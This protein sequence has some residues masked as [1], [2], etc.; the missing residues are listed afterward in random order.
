MSCWRRH[1]AIATRA[2]ADRISDMS[3]KIINDVIADQDRREAVLVRFQSK[4]EHAEADACWPWV[5]KAKHKFGYGV[6]NAGG[7]KTVN[8]HCLAWALKNGPI[9][10]GAF[11]LHSCDNPSCC[12]PAHLYLGDNARNMQDMKDRGR[13]RLGQTHSPEARANIKRGRSLNPP[14]QTEAG[15]KSRSEA[16]KRRWESQ[17]WREHFANLTSGE[18]NPRFGK[19]P[20]PHQIEAAKRANRDRAGYKHSEETK[21]KIRAARMARA[22]RSTSDNDSAI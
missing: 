14:K 11:V 1:E 17:E 10:E 7:N 16:M 8:A 5:A 22:I 18:R 19:A 3:T 9:P 15:R 21:Q 13:G 6:L 20:P 2:R 4:I 12:N